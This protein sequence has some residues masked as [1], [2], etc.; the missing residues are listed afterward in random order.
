M[1]CRPRMT[2]KTGVRGWEAKTS[3][4][5]SSRGSDETLV[6]SGP[7]CKVNEARGVPVDVV[8]GRTEKRVR[9]ALRD[10]SRRTLCVLRSFSR[11]AG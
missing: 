11:A 4:V 1:H 10:A 9:C 6:D 8:G 3:L 5:G 2:P 7:Q